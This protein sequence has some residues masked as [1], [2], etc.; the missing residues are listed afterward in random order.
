MKILNA[1]KGITGEFE[2][3]RIIGANLGRALVGQGGGKET[4]ASAVPPHKVAGVA[5]N[6][7]H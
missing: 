1:L 2:V 3:Q 5:A 6:T 4:P 7:A